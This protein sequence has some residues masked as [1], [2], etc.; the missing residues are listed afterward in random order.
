MHWLRYLKAFVSAQC[1]YCLAFKGRLLTHLDG[2]LSNHG[3]VDLIN[4]AIN[5][6][7]V[8]AV[9]HELI[10]RNDILRQRKFVSFPVPRYFVRFETSP[11]RYGKI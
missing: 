10:A 3:A 6:L 2:A 11:I 7:H 1:P 9:R 5:F 4:N 8:E